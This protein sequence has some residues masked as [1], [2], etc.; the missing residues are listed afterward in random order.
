MTRILLRLLG[1]WRH[2]WL[3]VLL[4]YVAL[5]A[6]LALTIG[7]PQVIGF[8]I[9]SGIS[10]GRKGDLLI[11][12]GLII[13]IHFVY[14]FLPIASIIWA[15]TSRSTWHTTSE[16]ASTTAFSR[17]VSPSMTALRRAN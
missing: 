3:A 15:S 13:A 11:A 17:S 8:A 5:F 12:A 9:D 6:S 14:G 2:H 10:N 16:T 4:A 1:Y 7:N